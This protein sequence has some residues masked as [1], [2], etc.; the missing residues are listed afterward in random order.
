MRNGEPDSEAERRGC[1]HRAEQ[2]PARAQLNPYLG[3][4]D[5][6]GAQQR[7]LE[8]RL[9]HAA[10]GHVSAPQHPPVLPRR[11][12]Q[13][14]RQ[15]PPARRQPQPPPQQPHTTARPP[16]GPGGI[17]SRDQGLPPAPAVPCSAAADAAG[18][19]ADVTA[20]CAA[21]AALEPCRRV[22]GGVRRRGRVSHRG[23]RRGG[24]RRP[25][26]SR[27]RTVHG[28]AW[29]PRG[30]QPDA[31]PQPRHSCCGRRARV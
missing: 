15:P 4:A 11:P 21:L 9:L 1:V 7:E 13:H 29:P 8:T 3:S 18:R 10:L 23:R 6:A 20:A 12:R 2:V 5:G 19:D 28:A 24:G 16:R 26:A 30:R 25:G 14:P 27:A 22:L 17:G 31:L